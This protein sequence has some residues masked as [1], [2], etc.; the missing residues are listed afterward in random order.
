MTKNGRQGRHL[1][2]PLDRRGVARLPVDRQLAA[3]RCQ[4]LPAGDRRPLL[5]TA[6]A[7]RR[8][9]EMVVGQRLMVLCR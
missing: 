4:A 6:A 2:G 3:H 5:E 7:T 8:F 1:L 9:G